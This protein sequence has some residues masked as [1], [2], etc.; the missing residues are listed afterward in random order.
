MSSVSKYVIVYHSSYSKMMLLIETMSKI[1]RLKSKQLVLTKNFLKFFH[2]KRY[3][4]AR[5]AR[6]NRMSCCP[7]CY[8]LVKERSKVIEQGF[9]NNSKENPKSKQ[10]L[11]IYLLISIALFWNTPK[12]EIPNFPQTVL[13]GN[14]QWCSESLTEA[15]LKTIS[16]YVRQYFWNCLP[17]SI[18]QCS[19][20]FSNVWRTY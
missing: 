19:W 7:G 2:S 13:V 1:I 14:Y 15:M 6:M 11:K 20:V 16:T 9:S 8:L 3:R 12:F 5:N 10:V 18:F 17:W 4:G